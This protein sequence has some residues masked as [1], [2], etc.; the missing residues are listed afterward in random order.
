MNSQHRKFFRALAILNSLFIPLFILSLIDEAPLFLTGVGLNPVLAVLAGLCL[1]VYALSALSGGVLEIISGETFV[2]R[3]RRAVEHAGVLWQGFFIVFLLIVF[4]DLCLHSAVP[5]FQMWRPVYFNLSAALGALILAQWTIHKKYIVPSGLSRRKVHFDLSFLGVLMAAFLSE[6]VLM[7]LSGLIHVG[8][9]HGFVPAAFMANGI[10]VFEFIFCAVYI[11]DQYPEINEKFSGSKEIFLIYPMGA[12]IIESLGG[13]FFPPH[14]PFIAVL[15]ALTPKTY[16]FHEFTRSLWHGRYYKSKVLVCIS[17]FTSN[18]YEAY[19]IAKEFKKRG[20]TVVM[21]GP[22]V[23]YLPD[24]ALAFCDSVVIG[25]AEGVWSRLV[26]DYENGALKARY[27]GPATEAD[28]ARVHEELL[29]SPAPVIKD[30]LETM[31]GCK[32]RCNFCTI[33]SLS[34]GKVYH[35]PVNAFVELIKK[36][37]QKYSE[38]TFID[39]NIYADPGYA[40]ELF[41]ALKPLKIRWSSC[42]TIDIAKNEETL[43]LAREGGCCGLTFGYEVSG[44]SGENIQGGKFAL[45]RKY[46]EYTKIIKRAGIN[47]QGL[48]IF[49]F[50]SDNLKTLLQLW[51]FCFSIMPA[52]TTVSLL[53]PLPGSAVYRDMMAKE[54]IIN[55]NWRNYT[56][57]RLVVR[58]PQM[59]P[60]AVSF[61]FPFIQFFFYLTASSSG[62]ILLSILVLIPVYG[63]A[64]WI[65][66]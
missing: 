25:P 4:I 42:C 19:K 43:K 6:F 32:F 64:N 36:V 10:H 3:I 35:Q 5:S 61:F 62:L 27:E 21:G 60:A 17:C 52:I 39:N 65:M 22:H 31:R 30:F 44:S 28:F 53:T 34:G 48:F 57:R 58:H 13:F 9:F 49:G 55:L 63:L 14:P 2:L 29:N 1:K 66:R 50:D 40:R 45:A 11:L 51:K 26:D 56:L 46:A 12:G 7:K 33:P 20:A 47:V 15:K 8:N 16:H 59:D 38:V 41:G 24:E 54:R 18:C 23:T 37:K